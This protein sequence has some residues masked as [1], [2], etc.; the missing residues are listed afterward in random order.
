MAPLPGLSDGASGY[1]NIFFFLTGE[2]TYHKF[3]AFHPHSSAR[4][5][6]N[7][8]RWSWSVVFNI[9]I[10]TKALTSKE[11]CSVRERVCGPT[12]GLAKRRTVLQEVTETNDDRSNTDSDDE[13]S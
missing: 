3:H 6:L 9:R 12:R 10:W 5:F 7:R 1:V 4:V 13:G 11:C 8:T 2:M